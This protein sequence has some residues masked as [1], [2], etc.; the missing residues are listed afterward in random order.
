MLDI[1]KFFLCL[2]KLS[3][4]GVLI[5]QIFAASSSSLGEHWFVYAPVD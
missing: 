5:Y 2:T 3:G 1:A 4:S